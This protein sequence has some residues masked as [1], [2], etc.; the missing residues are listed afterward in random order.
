MVRIKRFPGIGEKLDSM[1]EKITNFGHITETRF[2]TKTKNMKITTKTQMFRKRAYL[3][4]KLRH[5]VY[6]PKSHYQI[7]NKMLISHFITSNTH[8]K[9]L[10]G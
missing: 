2:R 5:F 8:Y 3:F 1:I 4:S 6:L 9:N 10:V 7:R